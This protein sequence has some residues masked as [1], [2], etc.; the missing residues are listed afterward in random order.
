MSSD[1]TSRAASQSGPASMLRLVT[2]DDATDL[3]DGPTRS[4][5]VGVGGTLTVTDLQGR[6][7][8]LRSAPHQ[9]HPIRVSRVLATGTTASEIIALY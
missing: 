2:P 9:Y 5:F 4:L 3:P 6:V 7:T 8:T 1:F